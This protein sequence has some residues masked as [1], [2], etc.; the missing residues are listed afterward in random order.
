M[1]K[2]VLSKIEELECYKIKEH[3]CD[4]FKVSVVTPKGTFII[5]E[6][7]DTSVNDIRTYCEGLH[8]TFFVPNTCKYNVGQDKG[9]DRDIREDIA[10][11]LNTRL[12]KRYKTSQGSYTVDDYDLVSGVKNPLYLEDD[13]GDI[14][15][16][17][18]NEL[19]DYVKQTHIVPVYAYIHGNVRLSL[20][21]FGC[22]FDSGV[23]G[24]MA[25][26]SKQLKEAGIKTS[27]CNYLTVADR[28]FIDR[29]FGD[30]IE[31][32][33]KVLCGELLLVEHDDED[34]DWCCSVGLDELGEHIFS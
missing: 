30:E 27:K 5:S 12:E 9:A 11:E 22:Q 25:M 16:Q 18:K 31:S 21:P 14:Y 15:L 3:V 17:I 10:D 6:D 7:C 4:G 28:D 19:K 24:F 34:E 29:V 32:V 20:T 26:T 2:V 8:S 23:I 1:H 33:N 13:I